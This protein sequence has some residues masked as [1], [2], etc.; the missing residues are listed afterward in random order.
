[1]GLVPAV[2]LFLPLMITQG[3][4]QSTGWA[5]FSKNIASFFDTRVRGRTMGL[6][7]SSY[8]FGGLVA[9]PVMGWVAYSV[10]DS[11]RWAF[12]VGAVVMAVALAA[13]LLVQRNS[14][15]D[16]GLPEID[17]EGPCWDEPYEQGARRRT[18]VKSPSVRSTKTA[19]RIRVSDLWASVRHERMVLRLGLVYFMLKPTRY[20]VLLWG[21]VLVIDAI[22]ELDGITAVMVPVA[23]GM[24]GFVA[25]IV[26]GWV[27]DTFF[28]ARR[29]PP[30]V[31][32]LV[33]L[34]VALLAWRP[35][36]ST[37]SVVL[38][39]ILLGVVGLTAYSADAMVSGVAAV[40][41][42]TSKHAA[43]ATGFI[44]G[45]GSIGAILGG[46][47]PG[48]FGAQTVFSIFAATAGIAVLFLLRSWNTRPVTQ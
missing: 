6:F 7:A 8:A 40:D 17:E 33:L 46:L 28:G 18:G 23:F 11:W 2:W 14:P 43:G 13:F 10:F 21:P 35:A 26:A 1:M 3:L 39:A 34:V 36:A 20:A 37:G 15:R 42:G 45:C 38:V 48:F 47:L 27:S 22:P 5:A 44:N 32:S 19:P 31:I 9:V 25:P 30:T 16:V 12:L 29:I 4:A 41:F 24:A